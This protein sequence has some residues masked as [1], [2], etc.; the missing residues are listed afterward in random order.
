[1]V[2]GGG[3][4]SF[5]FASSHTFMMIFCGLYLQPAHHVSTCSAISNPLSPGVVRH[6]SGWKSGHGLILQYLHGMRPSW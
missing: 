4:Q 5:L 6:P 1:M 3:V 2:K